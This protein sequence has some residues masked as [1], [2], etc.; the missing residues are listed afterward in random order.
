MA[1]K[2]HKYPGDVDAKRAES[3]A[4]K[5]GLLLAWEL[6]FTLV[7]LEG[8]TKEFFSNFGVWNQDISHIGTIMSHAIHISCWF[9]FFEAC[10]VPRHCNI[11]AD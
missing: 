4:E 6:G 10:Y 5:E 3:I 8:H 1:A 2:F 9:S 7:I 11:V